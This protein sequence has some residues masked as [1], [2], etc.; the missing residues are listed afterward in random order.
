M[1]PVPV[2][3]SSATAAAW[4]AIPEQ[5][6]SWRGFISGRF[7]G[8]WPLRARAVV[9]VLVATLGGV[10]GAASSSDLPTP[11]EEVS[12]MTVSVPTRGFVVGWWA[13]ALIVLERGDVGAPVIGIFNESGAEVP[14]VRL[15]I[16]GASS[17]NADW[18]ARGPDGSLGV[19]GSAYDAQGRG[20]TFLG[21]IAAN[22]RSQRAVRL[23]PF[24]PCLIAVGPD[25]VWWVWGWEKGQDDR[26]LAEYAVVRRFD[27]SG[28]LLGL[29]LSSSSL[30]RTLLL[31]CYESRVAASRQ[32]VGWYSNVLGEYLEFALDRTVVSRLPGIPDGSDDNAL[33]GLALCEDESVF[34]SMPALSDDKKRRAGTEIYR[35][36]RAARTWK[37]VLRTKKYGDLYGCHEG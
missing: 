23:N 32:R 11:V 31:P 4:T 14:R 28:R 17:V 7:G 10:D 26:P 27:G 30:R 25:G 29:H 2:T 1:E 36:D 13:G 18:V 34:V 5:P 16:P 33:T 19:I 21:I 8:R 20:A 22:G 37:T 24:V 6:V 9:W 3:G 15:A 35:L 12:R